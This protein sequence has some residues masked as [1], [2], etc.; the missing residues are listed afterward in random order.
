MRV[1][2][3]TLVSPDSR[4]EA[5]GVDWQSAVPEGIAFHTAET[6]DSGVD[7]VGLTERV[8]RPL[9]SQA[10]KEPVRLFCPEVGPG[11][12]GARVRR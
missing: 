12:H 9:L 1:L 7:S 4:R 5:D 3:H 10:K 2:N 6:A 11:T 8:F